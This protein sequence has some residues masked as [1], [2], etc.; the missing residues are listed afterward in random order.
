MLVGQTQFGFSLN[1]I[2]AVKSAASAVVHPIRTAKGVVHTAASAASAVA[3]GV[4]KPFEFLAAEATK[5]IKNRVVTLRNR[6]AAKLA[7]DKRRS[8][9]PNAAERAEAKSWTKSHLKKQG[10]HG[11]ILALFA[12][13]S[14][15]ALSDPYA[16][17][18]G[19][20]ATLTLIAA[21]IPVFMALMNK[22]L[23]SANRS[24][25]A[26]ANP[27]ADA[28]AAAE[29]P[30]VPG[31]PGTVDLA[32]VQDAAAAAADAAGNAMAPNT[33]KL[34]GVGR[35]KRSHLLI[36]GGILAAVVVI[37]LVSKKKGQ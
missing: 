5:P 12:G 17:L 19:D 16:G 26:P 18:L 27:Q 23:S 14:P 32:P 6:R 8:T 34:P 25:E 36:G 37:A 28:A 11:Q 35:V 21:S 24:G 3:R 4:I 7:M 1:P 9:T 30:D 22:V 10:P 33:V 29:A 15:V 13:S 20:P 2:K 31:A